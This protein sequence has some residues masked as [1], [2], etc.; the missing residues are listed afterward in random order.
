[1]KY[2]VD[3]MATMTD[4]IRNRKF[5]DG[6]FSSHVCWY[7]LCYVY[8]ERTESKMAWLVFYYCQKY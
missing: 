7:V 1:M 8:K 3:K 5:E 6:S 2:F 4:G